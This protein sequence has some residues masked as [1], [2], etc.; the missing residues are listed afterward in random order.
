MFIRKQR[1][2]RQY[3]YGQL[4]AADETAVWLDPSGFRCVTNKGDRDVAIQSTGH[5][6]LH[7]TVML[8]AKENG[9]KCLPYVLLPRKRVIAEIVKKI[10]N[11]LVLQWAGKVWMDN[12]LTINYLQKV[13]GRFSF[14]NRLLVWDA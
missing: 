4:Y 6:K 12:E 7:I 3:P 8:T 5:E 10:H 1:K 13:L 14:A 11:K 2:I 9:G